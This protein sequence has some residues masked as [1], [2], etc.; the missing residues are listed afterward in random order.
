MQLGT[1]GGK[2]TLIATECKTSSWLTAVPTEDPSLEFL[3]LDKALAQGYSGAPIFSYSPGF[4]GPSAFL[5]GKPPVLVG[6]YRAQ[7]ADAAVGKHSIVVPASYLLEV[8]Q[9]P[10]FLEFERR[11]GGTA[12]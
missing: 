9:Q 10:E 1:T 11:F 6:L 2:I 3:L 7:R 12:K 4:S 5:P 8:F